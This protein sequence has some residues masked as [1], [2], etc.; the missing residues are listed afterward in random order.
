MKSSD[1][2]SG[3]SMSDPFT[4]EAETDRDAP[5]PE[6]TSPADTPPVS[7]SSA[8]WRGMK[9]VGRFVVDC[10]DALDVLA[11]VFRMLIGLGHAIVRIFD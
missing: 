4:A 10:M 7:W 1:R 5:P 2:A 11:F 6:P 3:A 8:L 9:S